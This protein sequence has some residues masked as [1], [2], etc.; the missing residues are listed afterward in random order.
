MV[1]GV[2]YWHRQGKSQSIMLGYTFSMARFCKLH[3]PEK[4]GS[5][6][7]RRAC[8]PLGYGGSRT[9]PQTLAG[10]LPVSPCNTRAPVV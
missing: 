5:P 3:G 7:H 9:H 10:R 4:T 1:I 6:R 2:L 8:T